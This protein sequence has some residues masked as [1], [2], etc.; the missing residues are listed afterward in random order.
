MNQ[1]KPILQ[2]KHVSW[3]EFSRKAWELCRDGKENRKASGHDSE[4]QNKWVFR[5]DVSRFGEDPPLET[6][7]ER[8]CK[9]WGND[10]LHRAGKIERRLVREFQHQPEALDFKLKRDDCL[11]W[12]AA[13]QHYGA[14]TRLLDWTYSP[15]VAAYFAFDKLF[16]QLP[17]RHSCKC[18]APRA[19]VWAINTKWLNSALHTYLSP[20][21]WA[22]YRKKDSHS[23][24]ELFIRPSRRAF[25]GAVNPLPLNKRLSTQQGLFL[26]PRDVRRGW[27]D[28]FKVLGDVR[29]DDEMQLFKINSETADMRDAFETLGHMNVT[30]RSLFPGPDGLARSLLHYLPT[31]LERQI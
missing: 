1:D 30:S 22:L 28:N 7:L 11:S 2:A 9:S 31:H 21:E 19:A 18:P 16:Q 26:V 15:F 29:G 23:F 10:Y 4:P 27:I 20:G 12:L 3:E 17:N 14:P 8:A 25:V 24:A 13:M 5:G 6:S